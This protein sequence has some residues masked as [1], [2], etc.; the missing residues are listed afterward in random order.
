MY[1]AGTLYILSVPVVDLMNV[2]EDNLVLV[3]HP[4]RHC[5]FLCRYQLHVALPITPNKLANPPIILII[6]TCL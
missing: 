6:I 2:A 1:I 3:L 4:S 5:N